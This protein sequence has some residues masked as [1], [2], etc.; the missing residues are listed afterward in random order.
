MF[1]IALSL[2]AA[3]LL[4]GAAAPAAA[5]A[6]ATPVAELIG[7]TRK[8]LAE[9]YVI[10]ETAAK[11]DAALAAAERSGAFAG[12]RGAAL[13]ERINAEMAKVTADGHLGVMYYPARAA[14]L[15]AVPELDDSGPPP[16]ELAALFERRLVQQNAG[17]RRL[18]ILPG[19]IRYLAY[20]GF[21]W[22]PPGA[23]EAIENAMRFLQGGNAVII[24]LRDNGGG[25]PDAVA[26]LAGYFVPAGTKLMRFEMRG[27]PEQA[28]EAPAAPF[29]L[30]GKPTFVLVGPGTASAAEEFAMHVVAFGFATLVGESTAGAAF[31]NSLF[32]LPGGYVM[33]VSVGRPVH[34]VTGGDWERVG[35]APKVAVPVDKALVAAQAEAIAALLD[36]L[37]VAERAESE[38]ILA[39]HRAE[40]APVTP[41][42]PLAAY[43]GRYGERVVRVAGGVLTSSRSGRPAV[44]LRA[45]APDTF[46]PETV[47][48][49]HFRF[50]AEN[51]AVVALEVDFGNA[52]ER[53]ER[54]PVG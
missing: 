41:A 28:T 39:Y 49:Q 2:C 12:L 30:A 47:P 21:M 51:G 43:E 34:A 42:L 25:S 48:L 36:T 14:E 15:A 4:L 46:A 45:V 1:R 54:Q 9:R 16:P 52:P 3:G 7:A 22:G 29:S 17:V 33:S 53:A 31:R 50:V 18:E 23:A 26:A 32:A 38:R 5:Q 37:P 13:A 10:P 6:G 35:V 8:V 19:N 24:D 11:L 44:P 20:D 40:V 27:R